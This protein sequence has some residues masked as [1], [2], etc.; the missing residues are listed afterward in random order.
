MII[1]IVDQLNHDGFGEN[2]VLMNAQ[3]IALMFLFKDLDYLA[4]SQS[5]HKCQK[6]SGRMM[7]LTCKCMVVAK[8]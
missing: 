4:S 2:N 1:V 6:R 3:R 5:I 7:L 8:K